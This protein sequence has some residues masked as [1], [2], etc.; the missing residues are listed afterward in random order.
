MT[1]NPLNYEMGYPLPYCIIM[2]G[3]IHQYEKG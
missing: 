1:C 3:E 2:Y